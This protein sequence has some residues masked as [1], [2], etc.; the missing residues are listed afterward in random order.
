VKVCTKCGE[1]KPL[2]GFHRHRSS[3]DGRTS[4]CKECVRVA[5]GGL[6][7]DSRE[8][9]D[10]MA[11]VSR[12]QWIDRYGEPYWT[13]ERIIQAIQ[14]WAE[15]HDGEPPAAHEWRRKRQRDLRP[16]L[17]N[18][19]GSRPSACTVY[20]VFGSWNAA[21]EAAGFRPRRRWRDRRVRKLRKTC[22]K[23]HPFTAE[24]TYVSPSTGWRQCRACINA[25]QRRRYW[26]KRAAA[27]SARAAA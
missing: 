7:Q 20:R 24:N 5:A 13:E 16:M 3:P 18:G 25:G 23:G 21:I 15:R 6:R 2:E 10:F 14:R 12:E 19:P 9:R 22:R 27:G 11:L 17:G 26:E 4:Q 8:F 1:A